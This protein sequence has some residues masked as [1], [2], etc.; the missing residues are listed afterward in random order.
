MNSRE[1]LHR[2][3]RVRLVIFDVDGVL[4][5]G[6]IYLDAAGGEVKRFDVHDGTGIKY[7]QRAGIGTAI[8]SGRRAGAVTRRARELGLSRVL[9]GYKVKLD[10]LRRL[11]RETGLPPDALCFVGDDLIDIPVMRA[12]GLAV[13]VPNARPEVR[14]A[15]HW[16]TRASGGRGA[17]REVAERIL[18]AQGR[19]API[20]AR[21]GLTPGGPSE[22][23]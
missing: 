15:A 17:A 3:R 16:V 7:L 4:T 11:L 8:L 22:A 23:S 21:Y 6:G 1:L 9:Q 2:I 20:I 5:D 12:V 18:R 13:A 14:R 19:W 10:G